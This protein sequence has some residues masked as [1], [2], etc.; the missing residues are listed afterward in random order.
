V[1]GA[2]ELEDLKA[3]I[4]ALEN[5]VIVVG[6]V[7]ED[8]QTG[9]LTLPGTEG[10]PAPPALPPVPPSPV[11]PSPSADGGTPTDAG[12][13]SGRA[14]DEGG[15]ATGGGTGDA[16]GGDAEPPEP[17]YGS[18]LEFVVEQ[19]G[20]VYCRPVSPTLRW[21]PSWWEHAE[22]IYR[23]TALWRTWELYRL[24]PRLG[25]ASWLRDYL[26]PQLRELTSPTGPFAQCTEDR[27]STGKPLRTHQPP[28]AYLDDL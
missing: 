9:E 23:L 16:E 11:P 14:G 3:R 18:L 12:S 20:P 24:E 27:H 6:S 10:P 28:E 4:D 13:D 19:F 1:T 2:G 5:D 25:I 15:G 8:L 17:F 21:C 26:D 7:L 22:A